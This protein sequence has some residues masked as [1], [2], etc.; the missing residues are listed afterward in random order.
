MARL[1]AVLCVDIE[2]VLREVAVPETGRLAAFED[3]LG[4]LPELREVLAETGT[5]TINWFV[6]ID[7][8]IE[9]AYGDPEWVTK[10][11]DDE[12]S[13]LVDEGDEIG[14]HSHS[15]MWDS[16]RE[17]WI[18]NQSDPSWVE[19]CAA[20][21]VDGYERSFG[22][23]C[24]TYRHGDRFVSTELAR[25][26]ARSSV[27]VDLTLEPGRPPTRGLVASEAVTGVIPG[28]HPTL[29]QPYEPSPD[30]FDLPAAPTGALT[31]VPLTST[32]V[33]GWSAMETLILWS[34]PHDF[35]R[36]LGLRLLDP[37]LT[38]L[39]FALRTEAASDPLVWAH[40]LS[41]LRCL[42]QRCD[43]LEWVA[44]SSFAG[45]ATADGGFDGIGTFGAMALEVSDLQQD[46]E[47]YGPPSVGVRELEAELAAA[48]ADAE[49]T[50]A[51]RDHLAWQ[52][53]VF[54]ANKWWRL[55]ER[56]LPMLEPLARKQGRMQPGWDDERSLRS[57]DRPNDS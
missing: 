11:Y 14:A 21:G 15:W 10:A 4:Q 52:L 53:E 5:A 24:R 35:E 46:F 22:Q 12:L 2:P 47:T 40:V 31:M 42:S 25:F 44:A 13:R 48:R 18:S 38:H 50:A 56:V 49:A 23:P 1:P 27:D 20:M 54:K 34:D 43:G 26:L 16:E 30:S 57:T 55:R 39:A 33:P 51:E 19:H 41:N 8:Q 3:T 28:V 32:P 17:Q 45:R 37:D 29:S 6:R 7:P 9:V 36:R